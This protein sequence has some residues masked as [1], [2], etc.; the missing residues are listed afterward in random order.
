MKIAVCLK[1]V[2]DWEIPP[3]DFKIDA[4]AK[5]PA[6]NIGKMLISIFDE[7]A[8]ELAIQLKEKIGATVAAVTL[9]GKGA[10]EALRRAYAMTVDEAVRIDHDGP[11]DMD[12]FGVSAAL[13]AAIRKIGPV[14][15]VLCGRTGADWDRGQVGSLLA[16]ELGY[17]CV[18]FGALIEPADGRIKVHREVEGGYDVVDSRLPA[19]VTVTNHEKNVPRLPKARDVMMAFRKPI[20]TFSLADLGVDPASLTGRTVEVREL[21]IPVADSKVELIGGE[22]GEEMASGLLRR[23]QEQKVL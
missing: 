20:T 21:F 19:V 23:L 14:D 8:L 18:T 16:E 6:A 15:L 9:G 5:Q 3:R 12:A 10:E 17:A 7:N 13:A 4:A 11:G 1:Q 22:T 2:L